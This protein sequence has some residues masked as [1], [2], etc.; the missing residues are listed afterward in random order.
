MSP[1]LKAA[2]ARH[3]AG[4]LSGAILAYKK[5]LGASPGDAA[6]RHYLGMAQVQSGALDDGLDNLASAAKLDPKAHL[7]QS[8]LGKAALKAGRFD[9]AKDAFEQAIALRPDD[10]ESL[11]NLGGLQR[12]SGNLSAARDAYA[13]ALAARPHPVVALN[14]GLVEKDRGERAA[15][16]A[17]FKRA[18]SLR[19]GEVQARLQ[20]AGLDSEDGDFEASSTWLAEA[21][22]SAP[23]DPRVLA[24]V[25][26]QRGHTPT[27]G[28]LERAGVLLSDPKIAEAD[29]ARLGFGLGRALQRAG[30]HA[31]A[32]SACEAANEIVARAA[33][34]DATRLEGE[35]ERLKSTF[36]LGLID[37][38]GMCGG[39]GRELVFIVGL[40]RSGTTLAE[41]VLASHPDIFGADERPEIPVLVGALGGRND[42]YPEAL[43]SL[44]ARDTKPLIDQTLEAY[45]ALAPG[46]GRVVDKLPFNFSHVGLIAGL[47]PGAHI[48]HCVRD[49]RDV[50]VSCFFTEFTDELQAFRTRSEHFAAYARC[51]IDLMAHWNALLPGRIHT[52]RYEDMVAHFEDSARGLVAATGL[53]W[54][55]DCLNYQATQRTVRTPSRWQVRQPIYATSIGRWRDYA[56]YLG[57]VADL[58]R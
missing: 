29:R 30:R 19:P 43:R 5:R 2:I 20:L 22:Q 44:D 10:F 4:D 9:M 33:P 35:V 52:L 49:L 38:L 3:R 56:A 8:N 12:R 11:N 34:F 42:T 25:L 15:A 53:D 23:G 48:I 45:K 39:S 50:F 40:P 27:N 54:H 16:K 46:A 26:T 14:L 37:R 41:Q 18:V 28:Q 21:E 1:D 58:E 36:D 51:Y 57:P 13:G 32:W 7:Y 55:P 6:A 24:A 17:A 31:E 47:Y